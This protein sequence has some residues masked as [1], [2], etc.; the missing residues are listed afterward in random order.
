MTSTAIDAGVFLLLVSASVLALG[1]A[2]E[3][4]GPFASSTA[5]GTGVDVLATT[6]TVAYDPRMSGTDAGG[7]TTAGD[8]RRVHGS[9]R[10]LIARGTVA[11]AGIGDD[12]L[13]PDGVAFRRAVEREL[14]ARLDGR[15]QVIA[16]WEPVAGSEFRGKLRAGGQPPPDAAVHATVVSVPTP[17]PPADIDDPDSVRSFASAFVDDRFPVEALRASLRGEDA[18]ASHAAARYRHAGAVALGDGTAVEGTTPE[19]TNA[20]LAGGLA[21]RIATSSTAT[22]TSSKQPGGTARDGAAVRIVVRRW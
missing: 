19:E 22:G 13:D 11:G 4:A 8:E 12:A 10:G 15:T 6:A 1:S 17:F 7:G 21:R 3:P 14:D 18:A 20:A 2:V 9:L 5:S 16:T